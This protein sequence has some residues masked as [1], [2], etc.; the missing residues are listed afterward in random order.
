MLWLM[1]QFAIGLEG[2]NE[3]LILAFWLLT[4]KLVMFALRSLA[5]TVY[6]LWT[7]YTDDVYKKIHVGQR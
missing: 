7:V 2:S 6:E 3:L 4:M 1:Y 5:K